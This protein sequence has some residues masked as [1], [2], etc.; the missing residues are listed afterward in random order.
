[1]SVIC[2]PQFTVTNF[3]KRK[4]N[5]AIIG[6]GKISFSIAHAVINAGFNVSCI[7]SRDIKSAE[8]LAVKNNIKVYSNNYSDIPPECNFFFICVPDGQIKSSANQISKLKLNFAKSVF[9]HTS[10]SQSIDLLKKIKDK[11]G[12]AASLH[13]MQTFPS[14]KI[15]KIKGCYAAI[16]TDDDIIFAVLKE[17]SIKMELLPF[18]IKSRMK[19]FY[20]IAAVFASNFMAGNLF[21]SE[22]LFNGEVRNKKNF[23]NVVEPIVQATIRNIKANGAAVS[24]S[25]PVERGDFETVKKH[26]TILI[27]LK[28]KNINEPLYEFLMQSYISQSL[29]LLEA[30]KK[31]HGKLS[32]E[33]LKIRKLL[34]V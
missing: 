23:I 19:P 11:N 31:K 20:H 18:R 33:H 22:L 4:L 1:M 8:K 15:V 5:I 27:K 34:K 32:K 25:G 21:I 28:S 16:E 26:L 7:I 10:G 9:V 3:L 14:K 17:F 29:V 30:V 2:R 6:A 12:S 24:L 13:I